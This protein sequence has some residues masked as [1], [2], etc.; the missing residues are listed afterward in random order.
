MRGSTSPFTCQV[1]KHFPADHHE[2]KHWYRSACSATTL[3][4]WLLLPTRS[5]RITRKVCGTTHNPYLLKNCCSKQTWPGQRQNHQWC[6]PKCQRRPN[7]DHLC[8]TVAA[9]YKNDVMDYNGMEE[10]EEE[11][12]EESTR[13]RTRI[14]IRI[15]ITMRMR[16][17]LRIRTRIQ[18]KSTNKNNNK[19]KNRNMN[20]NKNRIR[21]RRIIR[22][23]L[24]IRI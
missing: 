18:I 21:K 1:C 3:L 11:E 13:T 20:L 12:E 22:I 15:R 19:N 4:Y 7:R 10:A 5:I 23:R 9:Y 8:S 14:P 6:R 24:R 2:R 17:R 16:M